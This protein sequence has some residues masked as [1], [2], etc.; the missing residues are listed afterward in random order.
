MIGPY[1][2]GTKEY[3]K[4]YL[5]R[6]AAHDAEMKAKGLV[7][8]RGKEWITKEEFELR[9]QAALALGRQSDEE[10]RAKLIRMYGKVP[11]WAPGRIRR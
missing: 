2:S 1:K 7:H 6:R 5:V 9:Y 10:Y 4:A 3:Q 8:W 11:E